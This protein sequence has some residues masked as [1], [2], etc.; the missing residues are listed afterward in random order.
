MVAVDKAAMNDGV[1]ET[2]A[3]LKDWHKI[4]HPAADGDAQE[5][6]E[7]LA[8]ELETKYPATRLAEI[9]ANMGRNTNKI[10]D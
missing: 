9:A 3:Y 7:K 1:T 10:K 6:V 5:A 8:L 2:D 4:V